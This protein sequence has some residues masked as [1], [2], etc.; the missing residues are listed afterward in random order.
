VPQLRYG[1]NPYQTPAFYQPIG[2]EPFRVVNGVPSYIN[3]LDALNGWQLVRA[4]AKN[5]GRPAAASF[6]HV[7]PAGAALAGRLDETIRHT[8]RVG[9]VSPVTSAYLRA[10]DA[11]PKSSY[12]DFVAVSEP[13]DADLAQV[14]KTVIADGIIAPGFAPGVMELLA[15]KKGGGFLVIE[16]DP[17]F[18]PPPTETRELY[19]VR[20]TQPRDDAAVDGLTEDALLGTIALRYT[21][22]NSVA[23]VRDGATIGI[24]AGQ[25]SRIDCTR[26][27]GAKAD[28]WWLRRRPEIY[29]IDRPT[30]QERITAHMAAVA[31]S[32]AASRAA[33]LSGVTFVS[34]GALPFIDNVDEAARHGVEFI[35]EPG[36]SARSAEV[37][38]AAAA[39]GIKITQTGM[40]LFQH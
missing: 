11:D 6:K 25:Q 18:V 28:T 9:D 27:A 17:E 21:Q 8:F 2:R 24:G 37:A 39:R 3:L 22:S 26:M 4:V 12:G 34:D 5:V 30:I 20:V 1:F 7:S 13:V 29:R 35:V 15:A 10:R 32:R 40:R 36:G 33:G 23:Y 16:A 31:A 19:G 14:L 38:A